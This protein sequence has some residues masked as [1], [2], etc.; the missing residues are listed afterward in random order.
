MLN[1]YSFQQFQVYNATLSAPVSYTFGST[2]L[3]ACETG[4]HFGNSQTLQQ[5]ECLL[6]GTWM[7][8]PR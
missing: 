4:Y 6:N 3:Y 2:I 5:S 1:T 7:P 8:D